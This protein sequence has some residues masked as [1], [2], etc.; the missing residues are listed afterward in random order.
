MV[1]Q[2]VNLSSKL[3]REKDRQGLERVG[4]VN[5]ALQMKVREAEIVVLKYCE[6]EGEPLGMG[7]D[8]N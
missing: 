2:E 4:G 5:T 3:W 7:E 8:N 6:S 1:R